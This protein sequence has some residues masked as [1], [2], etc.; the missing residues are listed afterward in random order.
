MPYVLHYEGGLVP[1]VNIVQHTDEKGGL[2]RLDIQSAQGELLIT[3]EN[4]VVNFVL[5]PFPE[6][7]LQYARQGDVTPCGI[8]KEVMV[9]L[10]PHSQKMMFH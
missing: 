8:P 5:E 1:L 4:P 10:I 2:V 3:I 9:T 7:T 6:G